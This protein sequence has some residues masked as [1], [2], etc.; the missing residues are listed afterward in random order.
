MNLP[1]LC[2]ATSMIPYAGKGLFALSLISKGTIITRYQGEHLTKEQYALRYPEGGAQYVLQLS[3]NVYIDGRDVES[4]GRYA[5]TN[6]KSKCNAIFT[7]TGNIKATKRIKINEEIFVY[8][9]T[10]F[11]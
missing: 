6:T 7:K 8:Y 1:E 3:S 2:I 9:G 10:E 5:N 11:C 4:F